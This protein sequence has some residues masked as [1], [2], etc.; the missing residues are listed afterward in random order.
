MKSVNSMATRGVTKVGDIFLTSKEDTVPN[1]NGNK[2]SMSEF[3]MRFTDEK[4]NLAPVKDFGA[5]D[6][7][8]KL[9]GSTP[10]RIDNSE[11]MDRFEKMDKLDKPE[12]TD[13]ESS[14]ELLA[15]DSKMQL[16]VLPTSHK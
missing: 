3:E 2:E 14:R 4:V 6:N 7:G 5:K 1:T 8:V 12:R 10:R 16:S 11:R 9:N 15:P 13:T